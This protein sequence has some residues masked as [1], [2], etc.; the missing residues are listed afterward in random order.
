MAMGEWASANDEPI[1]A[2][3]Q[4]ETTI[5]VH[6]A[7][8]AA[9]S[10]HLL[11]GARA[12]VAKVYE[13]IG[14]RT[15]W[16]ESEDTVRP[17]QDGRRHLTVILLSHDMAEK[18]ISAHRIADQI[19]GQAHR[20]SGRAY[21]F[22]DRIAAAHGAPTLLSIPLGTVIAH[23]MGH[24][25]LQEN[26]H[27]QNGLMRAIVDLHAIQRQNFDQSQASAIR[28]MLLERTAGITATQ[29]WSGQR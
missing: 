18:I 12:R 25:L 27:S 1:A 4:R 20:A 26:R 10:P 28:T 19:L 16:I 2:T 8:Y 15:V 13:G 3:G 6:V 23:E 7:N 11:A 22:C 24:L 9:L 5:V 17:R 21:I 29:K 14:V